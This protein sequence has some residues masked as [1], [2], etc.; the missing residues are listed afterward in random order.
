MMLQMNIMNTLIMLFV[1]LILNLQRTGEKPTSCTVN[2]CIFLRMEVRSIYQST[3][4]VQYISGNLKG[5][6]FG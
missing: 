4:Y 5:K 6:V 2:L 3:M 1:N